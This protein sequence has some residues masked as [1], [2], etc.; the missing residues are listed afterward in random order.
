MSILNIII[1]GAGGHAKVIVDLIESS[2]KYNLVGIIDES[3]KKGESFCSYPVLGCDQ[4]LHDIINDNKIYG[5]IVALGD[6]YLR[7]Q[8]VNRILSVMPLFNFVNII[9]PSSI[10]SKSVQMGLGNVIMPGVVINTDSVIGN[11]TIINTVVSIDHDS[12]IGNFAGLGPRVTL[13]GSVSIGE[14]GF[15]GVG[16]SVAPNCTVGS[17]STIG[18]GAVVLDDVP[19]HVCCYGIPAKIHQKIDTESKI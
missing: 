2:N 3:L 8:V 4:S 17:F 16:A 10:I 6:N 5:G 9:H 15:L 14:Q 12:Y 1:F 11:H 7:R 18:A 13:A 19:D